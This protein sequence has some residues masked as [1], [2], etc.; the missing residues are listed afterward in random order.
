M[1]GPGGGGHSGGFGGGGFGGGGFGGG[2]HG[3]YHH[4]G[5]HFHFGF[6]GMPFG[7]CLGPFIGYFFAP[8]ILI[9]IA[10]V[11]FFAFFGAGIS[12]LA[13]GGIVTYNEETF[14][15]YADDQYYAAFGGKGTVGAE[16][17]IL[18]VF[19]TN[20]DNDYYYTIAW[21]GDHVKYN[22]SDLFGDEYTAYG[23]TVKNCI[24][25]SIYKYSFSQA[26]VRIVE[27]ME[28]EVTALGNSSNLTCFESG[29][30]SPKFALKTDDVS[31]DEAQVNAALTSFDAATGITLSIVVQNMETVFGSHLS[32]FAIITI[33]VLVVIAV[34]LVVAGIV[35]VIKN[36][37][38]KDGGNGGDGDG[39][40]E[41]RRS[42][43]GYRDPNGDYYDPNSSYYRSDHS[44]YDDPFH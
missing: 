44:R 11:F 1:A 26:L 24:G 21:V 41:F 16:D 29:G 38:K 6:W 5:P 31:V 2:H 14:Q 13:Q 12:S 20:E 15:D 3:G 9:L 36:K 23:R 34:A 28:R 18:L 25:E 19:L 35:K 17:N 30:Q 42:D 37:N 40:S 32:P 43:G 27:G 7:G 39:G 33:V 22:V 10:V 4:H 8:V